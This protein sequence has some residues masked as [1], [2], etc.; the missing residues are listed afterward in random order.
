[1]KTYNCRVFKFTIE[2]VN[3]MKITVTTV[4]G[5]EKFYLDLA[6][7]DSDLNEQQKF[8]ATLIYANEDLFNS[9]CEIYNDDLLMFLELNLLHVIF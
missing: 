4:D 8:A 5:E 9:L 1:M 3:E 6:D 2:D 7:Y